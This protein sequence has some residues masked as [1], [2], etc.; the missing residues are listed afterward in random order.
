[1][2]RRLVLENW[3]NYL[4]A[5]VPLSRGTTF[6]VASNGVGK[7]SF[8][9]AARWALFGSPL[10]TSPARIGTERTS[11]AVELVLPDSTV[12]TATRVWDSRKTNPNHPL[13]LTRDGH[14]LQLQA[15][16]ALCVELFGCSPDLLERLT[17]PTFGAALPSSLGLHEHLSALYGVDDLS[18][19]STRLAVELRSIAKDIAALK[20][21]NAVKAAEF[22]ALQ[23]R[24]DA[25]SERLTKTKINVENAER[26]LNLARL[27]DERFERAAAWLHERD[28]VAEAQGQL[29]QRLVELLDEPVA[30]DGV[31]DVL[32]QRAQSARTN[33]ED[34]RLEL[35]LV[36]RRRQDIERNLAGLDA[37]TDE[38]PTCRRPLDDEAREHAHTLWRTDLADL[39]ERETAAR[40]AEPHAVARVA[41]LEQA[42][43][44][45][46]GIAQRASALGA[47][48]DDEEEI[49]AS[50]T[51]EATQ[52][53]REAAGAD[54]L[55]RDSQ[56]RALAALDEARVA[57]ENMKKLVDLFALE[58]RLEIAKKATEATR[59]EILNEIVEPL[60]EAIDVRWSS[61]F[62][63]R[64][65]V[66]TEPDGTISR[67]VGEHN[68]SFEAFSTAEG[69]AALIIMRLL[70]AQMTTNAT[71]A[72]FDEPLEHLDPDV[73]RNVASL[74]T[75]VTAD[76][77]LDQVVVTT[78][79]ETLARKLQERS[80]SRTTLLDVRQEGVA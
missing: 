38:C 68:L 51:Q 75:K 15:W 12:L 30:A 50:P 4:S 53:Y 57:D 7:T 5:D 48:A 78:Y 41:A 17:M 43:R 19:A 13:T 76:G 8:V 37:A 20:N 18:K 23:T 31:T 61:L 44:E 32:D 56:Q 71:F 52:G 2:I 46:A 1:M 3:R 64:G 39:V 33:L 6:V 34:L 29:L 10:P 67:S 24:V 77:S 65:T 58:A 80:P 42:Q 72:W 59:E 9:E 35:Q 27:R 66:R 11:A 70:V 22:D 45:L 55:A 54:A 69:T 25:T 26:Q 28:Q 73:R 16:E 60:A 40:Q 49:V 21:A 36:A 79:E 47:A 74:M 62:P 63:D 14:Y